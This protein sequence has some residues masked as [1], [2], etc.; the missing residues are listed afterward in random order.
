MRVSPEKRRVLHRLVGRWYRRN[1]RSFPWRVTSDPYVILVS[2]IMLQQTQV[3]RVKLLLPRFL[4]RFPSFDALARARRASVILAWQGMG[5]NA[6]AVRLHAVAQSVVRDYG[7]RLPDDPH[8]LRALPGIGPY[9]AN[10]VA[11]FA[12]GQQVEVVDVNVTRVLSRVFRR[13]GTTSAPR[14]LTQLARAVLP[15]DAYAWNQALMDIGSTICK[16]RKPRCPACPL[17]AVCRSAARLSAS[18]AIPVSGNTVRRRQEPS[19]AGIPRRLWRGK[20][21]E[22][23]RSAAPRG[24]PLT[25]LQLGRIVKP[26]FTPG[27]LG[28]LKRVAEQLTRDGVAEFRHPRHIRLAS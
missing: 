22:A 9:T 14:E 12:Y 13:S 3:N 19:H 1:G 4:K 18:P 17:R 27:E 26:G 7:G 8:L 2:E 15:G 10:A 5:Y 21:V 24:R 25:L 23:L 6:R 16:A 20:I 11:C 28:W